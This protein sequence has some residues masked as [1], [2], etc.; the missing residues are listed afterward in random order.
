MFQS[1]KVNVPLSEIRC[2]PKDHQ[3]MYY[4]CIVDVD[5]ESHALLTAQ[6]RHINLLKLCC[7]IDIGFEHRVLCEGLI[8]QGLAVSSEVLIIQVQDDLAQAFRNL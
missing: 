2:W 7:G 3:G 1:S 6:S 8:V 4:N 5:E